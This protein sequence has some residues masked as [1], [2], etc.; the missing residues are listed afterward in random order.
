[1][2]EDMP[3][4]RSVVDQIFGDNKAPAKDVLQADFSH[5]I[6]QVDDLVAMAKEA[7]AKPAN[8]TEQAALGEKIIDINRLKNLIDSKRSTEKA[9]VLEAGRAIDGFFNDLMNRLADE[10]RRLQHGAD[11]YAR[12]KAAEE[13]ARKEREAEEAR[14][15][16]QAE[17]EKADAAKTAT[18]AGNAEGRAEALDAKAEK[19]EADASASAADLTRARVGGVT[20]SAK[21]NWT[22]RI[23]DYT[24]A[25]SPL[26]PL[27]PYFK[28]EHLEGALTSMVRI[29]KQSAVW[30]GVS[31]FEETKATFRK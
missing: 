25:I 20:T 29:Q 4:K 3:R 16:A 21:A 2:T 18:A 7:N 28:K 27:G 31:F 9:P 26:G 6:T 12:R 24:A 23:E 10:G 1:M 11:D 19:L 8:D 14:K 15:R 13:R 17:R 30:P 22:F 5:I